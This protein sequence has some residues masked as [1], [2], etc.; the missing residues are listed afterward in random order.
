MQLANVLVVLKH[1]PPGVIVFQL[2]RF[3]SE[4]EGQAAR[5]IRG[6]HRRDDQVVTAVDGTVLHVFHQPRDLRRVEEHQHHG[7]KDKVV[8]A[9]ESISIEI[10]HAGANVRQTFA[11]DDAVE[12]IDRRAM[13]V[14]GGDVKAFQV[15]IKRVAS[16]AAAQ[17]QHLTGRDLLYGLNHFGVGTRQ[18]VFLV[19]VIFRRAIESQLAGHIIGE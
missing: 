2:T 7:R 5:V 16:A 4:W 13:F 8:F 15:E 19:I 12:V 11:I 1:F 18:L 10:L 9:A 6:I 17:I 14:P 3:K